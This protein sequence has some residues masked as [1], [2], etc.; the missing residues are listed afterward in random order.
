MPISNSYERHVAITKELNMHSDFTKVRE[1]YKEDFEKI[2]QEAKDEK[3]NISNAKEFLNSLSQEELKTLQHYSG[4]ANEINV[5]KLNDEGAYNLLLHHYEKFDFNNDGFISDADAMTQ[6]LIP[7]NM[8]DT[9]KRALVK[10][11][12]EMD[13]KDSFITLMLINPLKFKVEINGQVKAVN[14]MNKNDYNSIIKRVNEII[15]P[16][17]MSYSSDEIKDVFKVFKELFEKNYEE[18]KT[19]DSQVK[20]EII[21]NSN[22]TKAKL[23]V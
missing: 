23:Q 19:Q 20:N 21:T 3:V 8:P 9:E 13:E 17:P 22:I 16:Q 12:N 14:L 1:P 15:N 7:V 11:L 5:G 4:L 6:S 10:T 18:I 2:R